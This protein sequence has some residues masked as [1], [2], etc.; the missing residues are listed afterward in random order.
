MPNE[1]NIEQQPEQQETAMHEMDGSADEFLLELKRMR[2]SLNALTLKN[3]MFDGNVRNVDGGEEEE[4]VSIEIKQVNDDDDDVNN[5]DYEIPELPQNPVPVFRR[6]LSKHRIESNRTQSGLISKDDVLKALIAESQQE[7]LNEP[8]KIKSKVH[9]DDDLQPKLAKETSR[10]SDEVALINEL[11]WKKTNR[12][13]K[14][15][16]PYF[17]PKNKDIKTLSSENVAQKFRPIVSSRSIEEIEKAIVRPV[18]I[19]ASKSFQ[20]L[21]TTTAAAKSIDYFRTK[22]S[23]DLL[24]DNIDGVL[25]VHESKTHKLLRMRSTSNNNLDRSSNRIYENFDYEVPQSADVVMRK[26]PPLPQP[27]VMSEINTNNN[28]KSTIVYV[29][30]K[31]KDEFVLQNPDRLS[32]AYENILVDNNIDKYRDS[33]LF[34]FLLNSRDDRK[35]LSEQKR[36]LLLSPVGC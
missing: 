34:H 11:P 1:N 12:A 31:K 13:Y 36:M 27:R 32:D 28:K 9:F 29:L 24:L 30:D 5:S 19:F 22:S 26:R 6:N 4:I 7:K 20:E 35:F 21:P 2:N 33:D 8:V 10:E 14:T 18:P 16:T 23:D 17:K 3:F 15:V 25:K